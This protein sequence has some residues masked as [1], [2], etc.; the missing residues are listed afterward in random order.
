MTTATQ[1][2]TGT[3][4]ISLPFQGEQGIIGSYLL[5]GANEVALIDP[6]PSTTIEAL[7]ASIREAGFAPEDI[8]HLVATHIHLDHFGAAGSL[9]RHLPRARVYVHSKGARHLLDPS[10]VVASATR[11]YGERM[12]QLWGEIEAVP[13]EKLQSIEG[14]DILNIAGRRLEVHYTPGHAVHHVIFFDVH[15]GELFAGDAAGVRLQGI[16]YVRPPTPPPDLDLEAWSETISKLKQ[17]R[18]DVLYLAHFGPTTNVPQH[19]E[20][21]REKLYSW[22]ELV[23]AQM[24]N[25]KDEAEIIESFIAQT[26]PELER[27]ARDPHELA[28]Y[29][30]ATN[31]P[32]TVQG[33][34]RYWKLKSQKR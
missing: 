12:Q 13:Q 24:R 4:Q 18:P 15:S 30:I 6:G 32:M 16:D 23:L 26:Q 31:Y 10:K 2:R 34:M 3:W 27:I 20:R 33:Y 17:L 29:E 22:G 14:G 8:T 25:G 11:I 5:A 19:L 7:L 9:L 1:L 28:R 21:L